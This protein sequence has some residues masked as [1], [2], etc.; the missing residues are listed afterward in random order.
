LTHKPHVLV[1]HRSRSISPEVLLSMQSGS[2][3]KVS[4]WQ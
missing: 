1:R 2:L 4:G 3:R